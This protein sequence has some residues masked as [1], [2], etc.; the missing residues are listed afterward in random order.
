MALIIQDNEV[1]VYLCGEFYTIPDI[2]HKV[3]TF[4]SDSI[5][6]YIDGNNL[7][8]Q[9]TTSTSILYTDLEPNILKIYLLDKYIGLLYVDKLIL[10]GE[11]T[12]IYPL[13]ISKSAQIYWLNNHLIILEYKKTTIINPVGEI[14]IVPKTFI[15]I[16]P[17]LKYKGI[18]YCKIKKNKHYIEYIY[19]KMGQ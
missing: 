9:D 15:R 5:I 3:H 10:S 13:N 4:Y 16:R 8:K 12:I 18:L 19:M 6:L 2:E 7:I 17:A 14:N 1:K 11:Q